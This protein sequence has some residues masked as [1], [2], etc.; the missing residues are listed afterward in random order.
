MEFVSLSSVSLMSKEE[1]SSFLVHSSERN[2]ILVVVES[3]GNHPDIVALLLDGEGD[4]DV[5]VGVCHLSSGELGVGELVASALLEA[6]DLVSSGLSVFDAPL[7]HETTFF[8]LVTGFLSLV[9]ESSSLDLGWSGASSDFLPS[10]G[11]SFS[12]FLESHEGLSATE[13][14]AFLWALPIVV[15]SSGSASW[16]T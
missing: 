16:Y 13:D 7:V 6:T 4:I 1:W 5:G 8:V 9:V 11:T 15:G 14:C 3:W 10:V 2:S 12:T